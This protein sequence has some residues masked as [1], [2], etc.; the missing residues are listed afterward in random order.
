L[1][2]LIEANG[3]MNLHKASSD[4]E[5]LRA[6]PYHLPLVSVVIINWNYSRFIGEAIASVKQQDYPNFECLIVDNGSTDNSIDVI[7]A[8]ISGDPR[9]QL[10]RLPQNY[11]HLGAFL[12]V[13]HQLNGHFVNV[14]DADDILFDNFLSTHIQVHL[15][16]AVPVSFTSS[17]TITIDAKGEAIAGRIAVE[18]R[19]DDRFRKCLPEMRQP[20]LPMLSEA[21]YQDLRRV[22][23]DARPEIGLWCWRQGSSNVMRRQ[24][25]QALV[26]DNVDAPLF[27][28]VD[29]YFLMPLFAITGTTL[30]GAALSAY[31]IH[32]NNDHSTLLKLRH[33]RGGNEGAYL[34][35]TEIRKR[36]LLS[37]IENSD[38]LVEIAGANY[39]RI[40]G[41]VG[42]NAVESIF[43]A[44]V[45][46]TSEAGSALAKAYPF[47]VKTFGEQTVV[48]ELSQLMNLP[49]LID[50]VGK[51]ASLS[52]PA[53]PSFSAPEVQSA[54][55]KAYPFL[56]E[57]VGERTVIRELLSRT[58]WMDVVAIILTAYRRPIPFTALRRACFERFRKPKRIR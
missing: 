55:A 23:L 37:L 29:A 18:L 27:G 19:H 22:T 14:L 48:H 54:V 15:T 52:P 11:G 1:S 50:V 49:Q 5:T 42:K 44:P 13:L 39:F 41:T 20:A 53:T 7:T 45:F 34:R 43:V 16:T 46:S 40:I 56:I 30:I 47:L 35:N 6:L 36:C 26:F 38:K 25:L 24:M 51:T 57:L 9:F 17:E 8:A 10:Q 33:V 31:R 28:G 4:M 12:K 21:D 58:K 3:A 2:E 32:D